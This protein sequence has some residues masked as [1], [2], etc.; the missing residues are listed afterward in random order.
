MDPDCSTKAVQE[1]MNT[2]K[3]ALVAL[4]ET[5]EMINGILGSTTKRSEELFLSKHLLDEDREMILDEIRNMGWTVDK[6]SFNEYLDDW[7]VNLSF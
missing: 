1:R 6:V 3:N 4:R 5:Y 2:H 7:E